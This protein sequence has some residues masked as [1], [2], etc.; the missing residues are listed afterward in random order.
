MKGKRRTE[1]STVLQVLLDGKLLVSAV[2]ADGHWE[3][4]L[5]KARLHPANLSGNVELWKMIVENDP[6]QAC[7]ILLSEQDP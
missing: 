2:C 6:N 5:K 4:N 7:L 3:P 1:S